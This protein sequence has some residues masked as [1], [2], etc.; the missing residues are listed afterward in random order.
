MDDF[1]FFTVCVAVGIALLF[2]FAFWIGIGAP[3]LDE[4]PR[5]RITL[6]SKDVDPV[7]P[8]CDAP[9]CKLALTCWRCGAVLDESFA[10][11]TP[12]PDDDEAA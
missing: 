2:G 3:T 12:T 11:A 1:T 5:K 6:P 7:C 4:E 8:R 9:C 10:E